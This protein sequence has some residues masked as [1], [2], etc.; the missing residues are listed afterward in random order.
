MSISSSYLQVTASICLDLKYGTD[1]L[2]DINWSAI[3]QLDTMHSTL[4]AEPDFLDFGPQQS[5]TAPTD[6][7]GMETAFPAIVTTGLTSKTYSTVAPQV[8][9]MRQPQAEY[10]AVPT[11]TTFSSSQGHPPQGAVIET[12]RPEAESAALSTANI[13]LFLQGNQLQ[14]AAVVGQ[15]TELLRS[16]QGR[17]VCECEECESLTFNSKF[18]WK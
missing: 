3:E 18:E 13:S 12:Q 7:T 8:I 17:M 4:L 2:L 10:T 5:L 15:Q 16:D 6:D 11:F 1:Y 14:G 9:E